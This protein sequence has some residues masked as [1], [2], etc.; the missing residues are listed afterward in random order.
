[1]KRKS[2]VKVE[3]RWGVRCMDCDHKAFTECAD[4]ST[5]LTVALSESRGDANPSAGSGRGKGGKA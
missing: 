1:M 2:K 4:P 5:N 3:K